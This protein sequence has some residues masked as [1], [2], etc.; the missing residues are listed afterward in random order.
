LFSVQIANEYFSDII[1]FFSTGFAPREFTTAQKKILVV[2]VA[3]YQ[4]IV[5]H[6]YKLVADRILRRCVMEHERPFILAEAHEGIAGGHYTGKS[7]A[8]K[9][10]HVGLWWPTIHKNSKEYCQKCDVFQRVGN[11]SRRDEMPLRPQ[12]TLQVFNKWA[13]DFLGPINPPTRRSGAKYIIKT[14]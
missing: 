2:R 7:T 1:E 9:V 12:V 14:T 8:R 5:G 10:L 4:L 6:L 13:I 3:Y 11:P